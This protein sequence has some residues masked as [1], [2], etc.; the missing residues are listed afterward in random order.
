MYSAMR[1]SLAGWLVPKGSAPPPDVDWETRRQERKRR[2]ESLGLTWPAPKRSRGQPSFKVRWQALLY[3]ALNRDEELPEEVT[4]LP[5]DWWSPGMPL[6]KPENLAEVGHSAITAV[7]AASAS[8]AASSGTLL[9]ELAAAAP[10]MDPAASAQES[11]EAAAV[12]AEPAE[13]VLDPSAPAEAGAAKKPKRT[14]VHVAQPLK[15]WFLEFAEYKKHLDGWDVIRSFRYAQDQAP[16]LY[17]HLKYGT[18]NRWVHSRDLPSDKEEQ[19]GRPHKLSEA[20]M[21]ILCET[22]GRVTAKVPMSSPLLLAIVHEKLA[23]MDLA[24]VRLSRSWMKEFLSESSFSWRRFGVQ[25]AQRHDAMTKATNKEL[26]ACK[27]H[28]M[29]REHDIPDHRVLNMDETSIKLLPESPNGWA[30]CKEA[31]QSMG[32]ARAR[33][34]FLWFAVTRETSQWRAW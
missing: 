34:L 31:A 6:R 4:V 32:D 7:A 9:E 26:L 17:G 28:W 29:Q 21:S 8:A 12:A 1:G 20:V 2:A 25:A 3:D 13:P 22:L 19:R 11:A 30:K 5:P 23:E 24:D 33:P 15:D 10:V 18:V 14:Y 16:E 27:V